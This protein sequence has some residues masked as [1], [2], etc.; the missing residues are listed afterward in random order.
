MRKNER[1]LH[2]NKETV[3]ALDL[4]P[5]AIAAYGGRDLG[6]GASQG[7]DIC[8]SECFSC[9]GTRVNC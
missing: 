2:L 9:S 3:L 7:Q 6:S 1:K 8:L 5:A 4:G